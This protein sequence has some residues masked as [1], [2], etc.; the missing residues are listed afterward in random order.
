MC[1]DIINLCC[2]YLPVNDIFILLN[3][4]HKQRNE[5]LKIY[6]I[7]IPDINTA[8]IYG[9]LEIVK[10]LVSNKVKPTSDAV[11]FAGINDYLKIM[12]YLILK[13]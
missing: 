2:S 1:T 8:S 4:N 6:K 3:T 12:K 13:G 5:I 7:P 9:N 10:Y 11:Y